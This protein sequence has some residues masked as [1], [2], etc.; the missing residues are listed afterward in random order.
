M[1]WEHNSSVSSPRAWIRMQFCHHRRRF[2]S[3]RHF[4]SGSG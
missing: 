2:F 3:T 1:E 4:S